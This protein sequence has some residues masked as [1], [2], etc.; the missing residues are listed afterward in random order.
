MHVGQR[1]G[2]RRPPLRRLLTFPSG[3][4]S[5][6]TLSKQMRPRP[7]VPVDSQAGKYRR[8]NKIWHFRK[9]KQKARYR[10]GGEGGGAG[11]GWAVRTCLCNPVPSGAGMLTALAGGAL[12]SQDSARSVSC[13]LVF[14]FFFSVLFADWLQTSCFSR[15]GG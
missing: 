5:V 3:N 15:A 9:K 13:Q 11:G 4:L 2:A 12:L 10:L 8:V 1:Y 14:F 6:F 7:G